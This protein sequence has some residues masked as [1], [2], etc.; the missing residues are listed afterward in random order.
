MAVDEL[1]RDNT[2]VGTPFIAGFALILMDLF[3]MIFLNLVRKINE[4][5]MFH[6]RC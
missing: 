1:V 3:S 5:A 4:A 6:T 2:A